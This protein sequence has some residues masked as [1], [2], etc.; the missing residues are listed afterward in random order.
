MKQP[1]KKIT[2]SALGSMLN[3][4]IV[5]EAD[6]NIRA[7]S[8]ESAG[9]D[10]VSVIRL[11]RHRQ[12]SFLSRVACAIASRADGAQLA[13]KNDGTWLLVNDIG[14]ALWRLN[15][16]L[17]QTKTALS[18]MSEVDDMNAAAGEQ[19]AE[20]VAL[21]AR[22][23]PDAKIGPFVHIG[24]NVRIDAGVTIEAHAS[25]GGAAFVTIDLS[26]HEGE[27]LRRVPTLGGVWLKSGSHIGSHCRVHRALYGATIIEENVQI[28][29]GAHIGHDCMIG[30]S[31]LVGANALVGG[32]THIGARATI[33]SG[34]VI[35]DGI[36]IGEGA[37]ASPLA[38]VRKS[39]LAGERVSGNPAIEHRRWLRAFA[40]KRTAEP[41]N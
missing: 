34:A 36:D 30:R 32:H 41:N 1:I 40:H 15:Q 35:R 20:G 22:V 16:H 11:P 24:P 6:F 10:C 27:R 29:A 21:S 39:V 14:E 33:G 26:D 12:R 19:R 28:D 18:W 4:E 38:A 31:V 25:I 17:Y 7:L 23:H 37:I 13:D 3:A 2:V 5:G 9:A 8:F